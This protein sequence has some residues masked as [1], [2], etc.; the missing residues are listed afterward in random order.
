MKYKDSDLLILNDRSVSRKHAKF[1]VEK[2]G[3]NKTND[4]NY[5][6]QVVLRDLDSK[7]GTF[8]NMQRISG[9]VVLLENS[10]IK[11]GAFSEYNL[12]FVPIVVCFSSLSSVEKA[13]LTALAVKNG[14]TLTRSWNSK[15]THLVMNKV[16]VTQKVILALVY[17]K[18]IVNMK[19]LENFEN[20]DYRNFELPIESNEN[21]IFEKLTPDVFKPDIK[22][23]DLFKNITF[24]IFSLNQYNKLASI[25]EA[26]N[27]TIISLY[28]K[29]KSNEINNI[30]NLISIIK[31]YK[32]TCMIEPN[33]DINDNKKQLI[34]DTAK[35]LNQRLIDDSEI[36]FSIIYASID[37]F[38]NKNI[39]VADNE[40]TKIK[41]T[42]YLP[43]LTNNSVIFDPQS[44]VRSK[45]EIFANDIYTK[46]NDKECTLLNNHKSDNSSSNDIHSKI[47][48][49]IS[50][51]S[52][53]NKESIKDLKF[54][55]YSIN[56]INSNSNNDLFNDESFLE[57]ILK[58]NKNEKS[59]TTSITT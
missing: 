30:N 20:C 41:E 31:Q 46:Q 36:G 3:I 53:N 25:I 11:F 2:I 13:E 5:K 10:S 18:K 1:H 32:N 49:N 38:T 48:E 40:I 54:R 43:T 56:D 52:N 14:I 51:L 50:D 23:K 34:I 9:T 8:V 4:P 29:M 24:V 33:G 47:Q 28:D 17:N 15:C 35:F 57:M 6:P 27:G 22:R 58:S 44:I 21:D 12:K 59:I 39:S 42:Q 55:K 16:K 19:W 7:F 45:S 26:A 37:I